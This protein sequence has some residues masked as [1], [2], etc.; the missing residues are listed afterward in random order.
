[1]AVRV[2]KVLWPVVASIVI[3]AV[4]LIAIFP[5]RTYLAQRRRIAATQERIAVLS[6]TN[7]SLGQRVETL[8]TD[9]EVERLAR[10][11]YNLVRPGEEA[12]AILPAPEEG[13]STTPSAASAN[14]G[15]DG[16]PADVAGGS[17]DPGASDDEAVAARDDRNFWQ[18]AWD[19]ID[20]ML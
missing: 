18:R 20:A 12:Y 13:T 8:H 19:G 3:V 17:G 7:D 10:E 6:R 14:A 15:P 4:M 16:A 11:Q 5:T 9:A 2:R 1:M